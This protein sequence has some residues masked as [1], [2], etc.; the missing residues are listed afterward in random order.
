MTTLA[1]NST[2]QAQE[3]TLLSINQHVGSKSS[4]LLNLIRSQV[5]YYFSPHNLANDVCLQSVMASNNGRAPTLLIVTF[6]K[7]QQLYKSFLPIEDC[8]TVVTKVM[9]ASNVVRVDGPISTYAICSF[10]CNSKTIKQN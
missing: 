4:D 2:I 3:G 5:E 9:L 1:S 6:P 10:R 7:I 8:I